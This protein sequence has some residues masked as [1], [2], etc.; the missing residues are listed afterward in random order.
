MERHNGMI[1]C[2]QCGY[3][4]SEKNSLDILVDELIEG[5]YIHFPDWDKIKNP[6]DYTYWTNGLAGEV[7]ELC[8][9]TKKLVRGSHRWKGKSVN[10]EEYRAE[11]PLELGDIFIYLALYAKIWN[12]NLA[13][14][15]RATLDKNYSRFGE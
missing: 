5:N 3:I 12:I 10:P 8:N 13:D 14:A 15:V 6:E 4:T 11:L 9:L 1:V 2:P 7:G